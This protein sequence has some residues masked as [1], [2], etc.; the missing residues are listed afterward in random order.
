MATAERTQTGRAG[1]AA[2]WAL[3]AVAALVALAVLAPL[4]GRGFVLGYDMVFTPRLWLTPDA[5][6]LG[7]SLPRSVP[8]DAVVALTTVVVPGDIAQ[9]AALAAAL[10]GA[11]L[12][13]GRLVPTE[14][15]G[16]KIV[17]GLFYGWSAYVAER[18][19]I[20]HWVLLLAYAALPWV[21]LAALRLRHGTGRPARDLAALVLACVPAA[22][23]PTGGILAAG[24]ALACAGR[25]RAAVVALL[26]AAL[27]APW[28]VPSLLH[29]G[30]GLSDPAGIA[31]FGARAENWGGPVVGVLGLGGVW[32]GDVVPGSRANPALP[33]LV[34][35]VVAVGLWG[36][37]AMALRWRTTAPI[38]L[39]ALGVLLAA[40]PALPLGV[41]LLRWVIEVVPGAGLLRDSQ[42]WVAWWALPLAVGVALAVE[43]AGRLVLLGVAA[44]P[45]LVMPDLAWAGWGRLA[46]VDYPPDWD[47][48]AAILAEDRR[49]GD[50]LALPLSAFRRFAWNEGRTQLDPAPRYLPRP[51]VIDDTLHVGGRPVAGEDARV[52][53]IRADLPA[54]PGRH[55]IGWVLVEHGTPG[56]VDPALLRRLEPVHTGPWLTLYRV[57]DHQ[58]PTR[59]GPHPLP[60][61]VADFAALALVGGA[62]LWRVLPGGRLSPSRPG[63]SE[64]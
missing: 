41:D 47:R 30:G 31:A 39:G 14:V 12:G 34:L 52:A 25:R 19:F 63:R 11:V 8:V 15:T 62:L 9:K 55:G 3:P 18:L 7:S 58:E 21:A 33:V 64:E 32:N 24:V 10:F 5:L 6:G 4:L 38:A 49:P 54:S 28:W 59:P 44:F 60:V 35:V 13:A 61:L 51:V 42:K 16:A 40:L 37:R 45:V 20:G 1:W 57:P 27:N 22:L 46:A 56:L 50:V 29:A 26:S 43:R 53:A 17:A 23:T 2:G 48:V 36:M